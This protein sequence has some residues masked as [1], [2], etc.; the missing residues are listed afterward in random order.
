[1]SV[2]VAIAPQMYRQAVVHT[3]KSRRPDL[4]IDACPPEDLDQK[5]ALLLQSGHF[6][7][8][9]DTAPEARERIHN[10]VEI[11]YSDSLDATIFRDGESTRIA[12][13]SLERLLMVMDQ[14]AVFE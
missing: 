14:I 5:L 2:L 6:L 8:C 11:N 7:L 13:I 12:D 4:E 9:H 10:R 1:V 3:L